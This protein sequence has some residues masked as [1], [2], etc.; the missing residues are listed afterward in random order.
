MESVHL[1]GENDWPDKFGSSADQM[2]LYKEDIGVIRKAKSI[3]LKTVYVSCGDQ[4]VIETFRQ[5]LAPL[6][7]T[8]H[9][10]WSLLADDEE[11]LELVNRLPFDQKGIVEYE[12]LVHSK[13]FFG[14]AMSS[15]SAL[16]AYE[17]S[18]NDEEDVFTSHIFPGSVRDEDTRWRMYPSTPAMLGDEKT[19]L[20]VVNQFDIMD[21]FP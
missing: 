4:K 13:Y 2:R 18:L 7:Y 20:M 12:T 8:V 1:R 9:D 15:M 17:R 19:R 5:L 6:G 14:P 10:K 3:D 11:T 21:N 16:I